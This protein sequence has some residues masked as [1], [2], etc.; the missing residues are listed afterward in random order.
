[1]RAF[2]WR[3]VYAA[4]AVFIILLITPLFLEVIG[5]PVS[6]PLWALIRICIACGALAY[7]IWGPPPT[8]PF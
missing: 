4:V 7:V 8:A 5:L 1:M 3:V 6:G 2:I